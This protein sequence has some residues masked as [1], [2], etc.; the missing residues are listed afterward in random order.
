MSRVFEALMK[1]GEEKKPQTKGLVEVADNVIREAAKGRVELADDVIHEPAKGHVE[2]A[3][4]GIHET[5]SI[6]SNQATLEWRLGKNGKTHN[7]HHPVPSNGH[8]PVPSIVPTAKSW[9][10][11]IEELF[12]GWDLQRYTSFPIVA[13]EEDSHASEQYK[14]LR[15]QIKRLGREA[16]IRVFSV[17]SPVKR[18]GK[19]TVAVN[20]AAALAL[21][22]E[23]NV[24]L[25]D[26][27][28][29]AP[30]V[31]RYFELNPS[32]GL[33]DYLGSDS[34]PGE[35][36]ALV[37]PTFLPGL[38]VLPAGKPTNFSSELLAK[39]KM[40]QLM[41]EIRTDFSGYRIVVDT[42]PVLSTS[43]PLI[44]A[45]YVDGVLLVVRA[46][47]TPRDYLTKSIQMLNSTKLMG[48][49]FNGAELGMASKY[50]YYSYTPAN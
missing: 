31:H 6:E 50:Y 23:E 39:D 12:F 36:G 37:Q 7:G 17:T 4:D 48:V 32:P 20:L 38:R 19:S 35:V 22:Y 27:D 47:K 11:R 44:L 25:I 28:L 24:L 49:V 33:A 43:D 46:R 10:E 13:L 40:R 1:A 26:A 30:S 15:E 21:D 45:R 18:D 2:V 42:S 16:E 41:E 5:I 14:I 29:R 34:S 8:H 9:R 3:D